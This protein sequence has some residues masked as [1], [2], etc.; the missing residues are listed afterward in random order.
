MELIKLKGRKYTV[1]CD[2]YSRRNGFT[3]TAALF[4]NGVEV[5]RSKVHWCNRTWE[6]FP[7]QSVINK[8][9]RENI[10][11]NPEKYYL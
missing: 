9:I 4:A 2:W 6:A 11:K 8:V 7:Y 5:G 1:V 10:T 3:H